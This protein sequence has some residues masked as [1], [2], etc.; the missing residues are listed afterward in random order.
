MLRWQLA[1]KSLSLKF[2]FILY[3]I[4]FY[5]FI[6]IISN[7]VFILVNNKQINNTFF[8]VYTKVK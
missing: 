7:N 8:L 1:E 4:L 3:F 6:F 2:I 5:L